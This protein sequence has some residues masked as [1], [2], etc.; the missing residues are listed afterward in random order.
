MKFKVAMRESL[1][2]VPKIAGEPESFVTEIPMETP[3]VAKGDPSIKPE[4]YDSILETDASFL[5]ADG[6]EGQAWR[7]TV[8]RREYKL[9]CRS[10]RF[11]KGPVVAEMKAIVDGMKEAA[12]RGARHLIIKTDN[13]WCAHV[14]VS[15]WEPKQDHT[16]PVAKQAKDIMNEFE[17]VAIIHTRSK[18][19]RRVDRRARRAAEAR[20]ADVERKKSERLD[21]FREIAQRATSVRLEQTKSGWRANGRFN[22]VVFPPSCTCQQWSLRWKNVPLAGK[23]A[24]RLPCKHIVAA[25]MK[26][27]IRDPETLLALARKA[28]T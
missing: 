14:L 16:V 13:R 17:T 27:G 2:S 1:D 3:V 20:R 12:Q 5:P 24:Q 18:Y 21:K 15:L 19:I 28:K 6:V 8:N 23:R 11:G 10:R 25:A 7:L 22:V 26:E 4:E 9:K